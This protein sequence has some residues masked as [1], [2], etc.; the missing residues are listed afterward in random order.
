MAVANKNTDPNVL[1]TTGKVSSEQVQVGDVEAGHFQEQTMTFRDLTRPG[2][3]LKNCAYVHT[4][5]FIKYSRPYFPS[6][7]LCTFINSKIFWWYVYYVV[8]LQATLV[9]TASFLL[10]N[11]FTMSAV[12]L[13]LSGFS[14]IAGIPPMIVFSQH[15]CVTCCTLSKVLRQPVIKGM[16]EPNKHLEVTVT[17][18]EGVYLKA[19]NRG[20]GLTSQTAGNVRFQVLSGNAVSTMKCAATCSAVYLAIEITLF[21]WAAILTAVSLIWLLQLLPSHLERNESTYY[22]Y[23]GDSF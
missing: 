12:C 11:T 10:E 7:K 8:G 3:I 23:S 21:I 1:F 4:N 22:V 18:L 5:A 13:A 17:S 20:V 2:N 15:A 19:H 14:I 16:K 6:K 9:I